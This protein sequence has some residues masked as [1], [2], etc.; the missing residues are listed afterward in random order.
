MMSYLYVLKGKLKENFSHLVTYGT[1][2]LGYL[3]CSLDG[4]QSLPLAKLPSYAI[5]MSPN[6]DETAVYGSTI[7]LSG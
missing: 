2:L 7:F 5:L 1:K 4:N 3:Q 6:K